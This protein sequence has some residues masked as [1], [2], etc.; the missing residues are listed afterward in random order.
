MHVDAIGAPVDLGHAQ[1][2]EIDQARGEPRLADVSVDGAERLH[3]GRRGRI[4]VH[5]LRHDTCPSVLLFHGGSGIVSGS[6][7]ASTMTTASSRAGSV[8][9]ALA[10]TRWWEPGLS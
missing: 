4:V 9:L 10:L 3:P 6:S 8:S 1:E 7:A 2:H 5:P